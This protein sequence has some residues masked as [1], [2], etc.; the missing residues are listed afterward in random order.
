MVAVLG[1]DSEKFTPEAM[2]LKAVMV[3]RYDL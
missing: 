3:P 2:M 1:G